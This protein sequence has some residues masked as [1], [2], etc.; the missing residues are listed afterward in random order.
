M[1][2]HDTNIL[3]YHFQFPHCFKKPWSPEATVERNVKIVVH[4][5]TASNIPRFSLLHFPT[6]GLG[7]LFAEV[8]RESNDIA[9]YDV[10]G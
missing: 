7:N 3:A 8:R 6:S 5:L 2:I 10:P 4:K 9:S 1:G